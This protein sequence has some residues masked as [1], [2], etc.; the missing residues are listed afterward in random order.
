MKKDKEK[1]NKVLIVRFS[2]FGDIVQACTVVELVRQAWDHSEIHWVTRSEF[3]NL[4]DLNEG[5]EKVYSLDKTKGFKELLHLAFRLRKEKYTHVYDAHHNLRSLV[6]KVIL[7]SVFSPPCLVVRPKERIKRILLF[8]FRIN[9][10]PKPF[11]GI[12]SYISPLQ[13]WGIENS[14]NQPAVS[15]NF[16]ELKSNSPEDVGGNNYITFVPSAAWTMKRWP[17]D[18]WKQLVILLPNL[19]I[20]I[21][22]GKE[23]GFCE[24]ISAVDPQR[25]L[26]M[27]GKLSLIESCYVIKKSLL[28]VSADTGLL[29]VADVLD[30]PGISLM[31]PTAFGFTR[32]TK[33]KTMESDLNCRPCSK[34][35]SGKCS[36]NIYQK[37]MIDITPAL[38]AKE[39]L[40]RI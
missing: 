26:N 14:N 36:Q 8:I 29:H 1:R 35:G 2:S 12:E 16:K 34:D 27:A 28:V 38:V 5:I 15:W 3:Q 33:I 32:S 21:L 10:F 37:C 4:V 22:G 25:V 39:I 11:K 20:V 18:Y 31:G 9:L 6:L 13:K 24:D 23:D 7:M 40:N 19:K 17:V 30:I